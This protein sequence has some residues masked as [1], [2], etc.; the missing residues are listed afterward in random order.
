M[1][2][3]QNGAVG[4][5]TT[6]GTLHWDSNGHAMY[7]KTYDLGAPLSNDFHVYEAEWDETFVIIRIDGIEYY[8]IDITPSGLYAFHKPFFLLFNLAI[9]GNFFNPAI[10]NPAVV[11][12]TPQSMQV[13]WVRVYKKGDTNTTTPIGPA[14][15]TWCANENAS[16][17]LNGTCDVAYGANGSFTYLYSQSGTLAFTNSTFGRDPL[18][19]VVKYGFYKTSPASPG[20]IEA[21]NYSVMSGVQTEGCSDTGAGSDVGYIDATD[22]MVYPINITQ[23]GNYTIRYR[24]ASQSG[25]GVITP[26]LDANA[27]VLPTIAVPST[28]AWQ[29]WTTISQN[30]NLPSGGHNFGVYA[31]AGGWNLNWLSITYNG[32]NQ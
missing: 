21:E 17:A 12:A 5:R 13:D 24:V 18:P 9:G 26:N 28:S 2:G 4:D 15:Y 32:P 19:N 14:G 30:V 11:A 20:R 23:A 10:T 7:G 27:I 25:G 16:F 31:T 22:W 8:R 29:S 1:A 3:G 6:Y